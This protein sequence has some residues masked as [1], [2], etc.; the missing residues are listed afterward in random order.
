MALPER[1][2]RAPAGA[3]DAA[4]RPRN[5]LLESTRQAERKQGLGRLR[6]S[7]ASMSAEARALLHAYAPRALL[8]AAELEARATS[9]GPARGWSVS[10]VRVSVLFLHFG[11]SGML[12]PRSL[13][14]ASMHA[15]V[16]AAQRGVFGLG[17]SVE[18]FVVDDKGCVMKA[19]F[20]GVDDAE[21]A[22]APRAL[23]CALQLRHALSLHGMQPSL[24]VA[25]GEALAGPVGAVGRQEFTAHG[26]P[27]ILAARLMQLAMQLGGMVLCDQP[28]HDATRDDVE[29]VQLR[30]TKLKGLSRPLA[31][32]RPVASA[33]LAAPPPLRALP[34]DDYLPSPEAASAIE[35]CAAWRA[36][37]APPFACV[38]IGGPHGAGKTQLLLQLRAQLEGGAEGA[39][40]R[41]VVHV[42]CRAH[43]RRTAGA[44]LRRLFAQL[45]AHDVWP[46]LQ[47]L[48]PLDQ[49][50][51]DEEEERR[52]AAELRLLC[53][54]ALGEGTAE[55]PEGGRSLALLVDDLGH[56]DEHSRRLLAR[57]LRERPKG[58]LLLLACRSAPLVAE[59]T[60]AA[61]PPLL[62]APLPSAG[63]AEASGWCTS[64]LL[65]PLDGAQLRRLVCSLAQAALPDQAS[66]LLVRRSA[67]SPLLCAA[68]THA[69]LASG[70]LSDDGGRLRFSETLLARGEAAAARALERAA[71]GALAEARRGVLCVRLASLS[72]LQR[73]LLKTLCL[74]RE[75]CAPATLL[76]AFPLPLPRVALLAEAEALRK[77][78]ILR[79][80]SRG[81]AWG[82]VLS[83][84]GMRQV[85][86]GTMVD[87]Q[88]RQVR[89]TLLAS[90]GAAMEE[91]E[92][93]DYSEEEEGDE[94]SPERASPPAS[95]A[96]ARSPWRV[97]ALRWSKEALR[98]EGNEETWPSYSASTSSL[99]LSLASSAPS[100]SLS[101]RAQPAPPSARS[102]PLPRLSPGS[103]PPS[104]P[105]R[106]LWGARRE[107]ARSQP[108]SPKSASL[109]RGAPPSPSRVAPLLP[110][111]L[112][113]KSAKGAA[114]PS[115]SRR[116]PDNAVTPAASPLAPAAVARVLAPPLPPIPASAGPVGAT[117]VVGSAGYSAEALG[118]GS[119]LAASSGSLLSS[120]GHVRR[121]LVFGA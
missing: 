75:P 6:P 58:V 57:L 30:P 105:K 74:L 117:S 63:S 34:P 65:G 106:R 109:L 76:R 14:L 8:A 35:R 91:M 98:A 60:P 16:L 77:R 31:P 101:L 24:G 43:E 3:S 47:H 86:R 88:R 5:F 85:L 107:S 119:W 33:A 113:H 12:D 70:A 79:R 2:G 69:L 93:M 51:G 90:R 96:E 19:L 102:S 46:A 56:C 11:V 104:P 71:S 48:R 84:V 17:G 67:G 82:Y 39:A 28:T 27:V 73:L 118:S 94:G 97:R 72:M 81:P 80:E 87:S 22:A 68:L 18:R 10:V 55:P 23:L 66:E 26:A 83:E 29:C 36:A 110:A 64:L 37:E 1:D 4:A 59:P 61:P 78:G 45:C 103:A 89:A 120:M 52:G 54:L 50:S 116:N 32:F 20:G 108:S 7:M 38:Q 13:D 41:R 100:A 62:I 92:E 115:S 49:A 15:A 40:P 53:R 21:E 121:R 114:S 42:R 9:V 99:G 44:L 25:T 111:S 95:P 112:A